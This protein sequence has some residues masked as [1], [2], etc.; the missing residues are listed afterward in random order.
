M[1]QWSLESMNMS[2]ALRDG[3]VFGNFVVGVFNLKYTKSTFGSF[4]DVPKLKWFEIIT[5][6]DHQKQNYWVYEDNQ[7]YRNPRSPTL[8]VWLN[9]YRRAYDAAAFA[10]PDSSTEAC[11]RL[12][13]SQGKS[14]TK[15]TF[16]S[17]N[18]DSGAKAI[19]VRDY[20]KSN[21]GFLKIVVRDTPALLKVRDGATKNMER[22]L[23]FQC[24]VEG[25]DSSKWQKYEQ[26]LKMDSA[27]G[28]GA[29][30]RVCRPGWLMTM[31]L[32]ASYT[33]VKPPDDVCANKTIVDVA[34]CKLRGEYF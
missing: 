20:L 29:W 30:K 12:Y 34:G 31:R 5:V 28:I 4:Q 26:Y 8:D 33:E 6:I 27:V 9:K 22:L 32:P 21:G 3:T 14:L 15:A 17:K 19:A 24:G 7:Y 10:D 2:D 18:E 1:G 11:S 23:Q 16:G 25:L 13:D